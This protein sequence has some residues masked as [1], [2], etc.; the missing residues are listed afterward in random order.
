[1]YNINIKI[2][3]GAWGGLRLVVA[4]YPGHA[5]VV[6]FVVLLCW[7]T[8]WWLLHKPQLRCPKIPVRKPQD[9]LSKIGLK[10]QASTII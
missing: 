4:H 9:L 5:L 3:L 10:K 6:A 2:Y 7:D 8:P 1:M